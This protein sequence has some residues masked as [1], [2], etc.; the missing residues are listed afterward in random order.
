[1]RMAEL[2]TRS[3]VSIPSIKFYLREGLLPAGERTSR[4]QASY[5]DDHLKRL[6]L[7]RALA[8]T[9]GLSLSRIR[10][11]LDHLRVDPDSLHAVFGTVLAA[12]GDVAGA[13]RRDDVDLG[14]AR[15][16]VTELGWQVPP[17]CAQ[18][19]VLA[20]G[21]QAMVAG[22]FAIP[23]DQLVALAKKM[24]DIAEIEL[25]GTPTESPEAALRYV[26]LGTVLMRPVLLA[27]RGLA[28]VEQSGRRFGASSRANG[29]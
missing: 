28:H 20:E 18:V 7:I 2:S 8:E 1:M 16:L 4:T 19:R 9:G 6:R 25:A 23:H 22:D 14:P 27:L 10:Q 26:V 3:G 21:L 5:S 11:V 13:P 15:A 24:N 17:D 12:D 29:E